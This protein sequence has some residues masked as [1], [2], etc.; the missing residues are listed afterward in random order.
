MKNTAKFFFPI[1]AIIS[2]NGCV[3]QTG[4]Y[5]PRAAFDVPIKT[6]KEV[7]YPYKWFDPALS[8]YDNKSLC[9]MATRNGD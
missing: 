7:S 2:L 6:A 9:N 1:L 3:N 4:G 5:F 8:H